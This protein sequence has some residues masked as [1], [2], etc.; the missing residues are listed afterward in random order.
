[1]PLVNPKRSLETVSLTNLVT[2][3]I[4]RVDMRGLRSVS[5][6]SVID[7]NTPSAVLSP[8]TDVNTT[9]DAI[10]EVA[11]GLTTGVKGQFTTTGGLPAGI[12]ASTDYFVIRV[13]ADNY[14]VATSLA[15]ALAGTAVDITTQGT[16]NHTFTPTALAGAAYRYKWS[17]RPEV[18]VESYT[19]DT[20]HW[21]DIAAEVA[22]TADA[23]AT[24]RVVD[25][26]YRVLGLYA[27]LTA[28][29]MTIDNYLTA[30]RIAHR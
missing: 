14:K 29:R 10:L 24:I 16:G 23:T 18:L 11:H 26:E 20:A 27:T 12:S 4:V 6:Q 8:S 9:S 17:N 5:I 21:A 28:G 30:E 15:L 2:T 22:V 13:D 25:P 7:V 3:D 19:Y 1:M